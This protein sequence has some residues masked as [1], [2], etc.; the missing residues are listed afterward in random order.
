MKSLILY[1]LL[2]FV[3][4]GMQHKVMFCLPQEPNP[5]LSIFPQKNFINITHYYRKTI[6]NV[7]SRTLRGESKADIHFF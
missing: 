2:M 5:I 6:C 3:G 4:E 1:A 7:H